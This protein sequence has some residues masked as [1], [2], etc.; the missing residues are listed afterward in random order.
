MLATSLTCRFP[1]LFFLHLSPCWHAHLTLCPSPPWPPLFCGAA[2]GHLALSRSASLPAAIASSAVAMPVYT[3]VLISPRTRLATPPF[4]FRAGDSTSACRVHTV[5]AGHSMSAPT[6]IIR[7]PRGFAVCPHVLLSPH[8]CL[9]PTPATSTCPY[10]Y[11]D[12]VVHR[13]EASMGIAHQRVAACALFKSRCRSRSQMGG[14]SPDETEKGKKRWNNGVRGPRA[15]GVVEMEKDGLRAS[16]DRTGHVLHPSAWA[17]GVFALHYTM[18]RYEHLPRLAPSITHSAF[19]RLTKHVL[20]KGTAHSLA[21]IPFVPVTLCSACLLAPTTPPFLAPFHPLALP[22]LH[23]L[24]PLRLQPARP[25]LHCIYL[26][27][28]PPLRFPVPISPTPALLPRFARRFASTP[29]FPLRPSTRAPAIRA[30]PVPRASLRPQRPRSTLRSSAH[31]PKS[32]C[33]RA[34]NLPILPTLALVH[35]AVAPP[36]VSFAAAAARHAPPMCAMQQPG[37][38]PQCHAHRCAVLAGDTLLAC[39]ARS[40]STMP[41]PL[42]ACPAPLAR[43]LPARVPGKAWPILAHGRTHWGWGGVCAHVAQDG[44]A[45]ERDRCGLVDRGRACPIHIPSLRYLHS[46]YRTSLTPRHRSTS[47]VPE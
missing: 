15:V 3:A 19:G 29:R 38:L 11:D 35:R 26:C 7:T 31:A 45:N 6:R 18:S 22:P 46:H 13:T 25:C 30:S 8:F 33:A 14:P 40:P 20:P 36:S 34:P 37:R 24:R 16:A 32:P 42:L 2:R 44:A 43:S 9:A 28:C 12:I 39:P 23:L 27:P 47:L 10:V 1:A 41:C 4:P 5:A 17:D 21:R